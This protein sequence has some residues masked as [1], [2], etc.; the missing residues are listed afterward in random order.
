M[1]PL[2]EVHCSK[3]HTEIAGILLIEEA[4]GSGEALM[5]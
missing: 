1:N 3:G 5:V 2:R 4:M